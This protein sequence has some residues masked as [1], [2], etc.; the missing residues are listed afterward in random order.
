M[1]AESIVNALSIDV[2]EYF[3]VSAFE[4]VIACD[5][6]DAWPSRVEFATNQLLDLFARSGVHTTFFTL[7]WVAERHPQLIRRLCQEGHELACHGYN[8]TRATTQTQSEFR[9]DVARSKAILE[10]I[11]GVPVVGYRAASFSIDASNL[12]AF[13]EIEAA[14]FT[15]SSSVYPVRHDLYG[16]PNAPRVPFR[17]P[18]T[19]QLTEIPVSTVR[20][21]SRNLPAGGGGFFRLL[22][23]AVSRALIR[24]VN[25]REQLAANMYFHPWEFDPQQPR[26]TGVRLKSRFRH[27]HNQSR[28]LAR[29][30][31]L[32]SDFSWAPFRD[33]YRDV[34]AGR[35][36]LTVGSEVFARP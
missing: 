20:F 31:S 22:P 33:V 16:A 5:K 34:L 2:E 30:R 36:S 14:G 18:S 32:M 3:Q 4:S 17:P 6:W 21:G 12:W 29:L 10:D 26:P 19:T 24:R 13:P 28:A 23:Y 11:A 25:L 1:I 35:C 7:G 27:Y 8:H 9:A 15:Y